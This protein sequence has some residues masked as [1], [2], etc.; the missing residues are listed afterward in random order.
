MET[1]LLAWSRT[2]QSMAQIGLTY[3]H[4]PFDRARYEH[5]RTLAAEM[6]ASC[7]ELPAEHIEGLFAAERGYATPKIDVRGGVFRANTILLVRERSDGLWSLPGGWA[8]LNESAGESVVRE[9]EEEAGFTTHPVK[10][11][12]VFDR[13]KHAHPPMYFHVYKMFFLCD[14]V[15]G[16]SMES[17]ETDRAEF[18]AAD[19]L[20]PLS[21]A[22]VT[23]DQIA[24]LFRHHANR[25][26]PT[27]FD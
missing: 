12:A 9:I 15:R 8:D 27:V 13:N 2:I 3:T 6:V 24:L 1:K 7:S 4:D 14:I 21:L 16:V 10:L 22:R 17:A 18:F 20:P 26:L 11:V 19:A 23:P 25:A 5:L